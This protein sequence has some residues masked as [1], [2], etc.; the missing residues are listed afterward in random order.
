MTKQFSS[1]Q[2]QGRKQ[3]ARYKSFYLLTRIL[4]L[5]GLVLLRFLQMQASIKPTSLNS[6]LVFVVYFAIQV[7]LLS[8]RFAHKS[9]GLIIAVLILEVLY[10]IHLLSHM[11]FGWVNAGF[12]RFSNIQGALLLTQVVL[13]T[14]FFLLGL[15]SLA[16]SWLWLRSYRKSRA[17]C[18]AEEAE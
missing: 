10:V 7:V 4:L 9:Q 18:D 16:L 1:I 6:I 3:R 8:E 13:P 2:E 12:L 5:A 14:L 11:I 15:L 17:Y